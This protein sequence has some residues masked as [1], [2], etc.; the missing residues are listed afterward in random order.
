MPNVHRQPLIGQEVVAHALDITSQAISNWYKREA[1]D[2][3]VGKP[4]WKMPVPTLIE[5]TEG[6]PPRKAWRR[7]Q[8][9]VWQ[10]WFAKHMLEQGDHVP[11]KQRK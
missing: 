5:F 10:K 3:A 9:P 4:S 8:I 2:M 6:K 1:E 11:L 7:A